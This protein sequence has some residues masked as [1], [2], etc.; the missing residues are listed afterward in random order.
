MA[1]RF[2][3][4]SSFDSSAWIGIIPTHI[5]HGSETLNDQHDLTYKYLK[6]K[7]GGVFTYHAPMKSGSFD[8]RMNDNDHNG[9]EVASITFEVEG[10]A[11]TEIS[12]NVSFKNT[13]KYLFR[14]G[15]DHRGIFRSSRIR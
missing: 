6:N 15:N 10:T 12:E 5:T 9:K 13:K 7:T 3:A 8:F 4:P 1:I 11:K 14:S 2:T